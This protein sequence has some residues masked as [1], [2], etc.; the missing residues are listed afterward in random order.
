MSFLEHSQSPS[1]ALD[2]KGSLLTL[3]A[4]EVR[5]HSRLPIDDRM[6]AAHLQGALNL[7][8]E[9]LEGDLP[10]FERV[11]RESCRLLLARKGD[12]GSASPAIQALPERLLRRLDRLQAANTCPCAACERLARLRFKVVVHAG[13]MLACRHGRDWEI[14]GLEA[15]R[16]H[17][18]SRAGLEGAACLLLSEPAAR[19]LGV[20]DGEG[21]E[22][23]ELDLDGFGP[24]PVWLRGWDR[25]DQVRRASLLARLGMSLR[26]VFWG[27][28][29]R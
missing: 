9:G 3:L 1:V 8:L 10:G 29:Q 13:E 21:F 5:G 7:L 4:I 6:A 26:K 20:E 11:H 24:V 15:T 12:P 18:L 17:R 23:L 19:L 25:S 2:G 14:T 28:R 27:F 22:S 16:H